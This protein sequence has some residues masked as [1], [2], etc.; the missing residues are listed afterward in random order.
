MNDEK[1]ICMICTY[2]YDPARG[3]PEGGIPP[4]VPFEDLPHDWK[5]PTC[6]AGKEH[7]EPM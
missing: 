6:G 2:E 4:G 1:Y 7:F 5:C 3:D